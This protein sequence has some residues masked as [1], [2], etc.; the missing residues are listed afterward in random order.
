MVQDLG[1]VR[2]RAP[3]QPP[4]RPARKKVPAAVAWVDCDR[5]SGCEVC[6]AFCPVDCIGLVRDAEM[7]TINPTCHVVVDECIG[8][9]ICV[10]QCPWDAIEMVRYDARA[11]AAVAAAGEPA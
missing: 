6:I 11:A 4:S 1:A 7:P 3:A 10:E 8:C 9:K 2:E 5:C